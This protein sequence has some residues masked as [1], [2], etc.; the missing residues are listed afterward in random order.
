MIKY[1]NKSEVFEEEISNGNYLVDFY[2]DWCGPC[3]MISPVLESLTDVNVI[4]VN[5]DE[6]GEVA[7]KYGVMSIP[8]LIYFKD[9]V[10]SSKAIGFKNKAEI[11]EL[12]KQKNV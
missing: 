12:I 7:N 3:K 6:F 2:A 8:T 11:E 10:E 5:V 1:L 4:K 9:G